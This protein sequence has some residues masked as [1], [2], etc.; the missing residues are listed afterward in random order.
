MNIGNKM[1]N[2][3]SEEY[4]EIFSNYLIMTILWGI[5]L[6][7]P[8]AMV[9]V[10]LAAIDVHE[11]YFVIASYILGINVLFWSSYIGLT[12][13]LNANYKSFSITIEIIKK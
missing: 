11:G 1:I 2:W 9:L 5:I 10:L 6:L 7:I 13:A 3:R 4:F 12:K 8:A